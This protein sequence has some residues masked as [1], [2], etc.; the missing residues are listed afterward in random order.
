MEQ[1]KSLRGY[2]AADDFHRDSMAHQDSEY[3]SLL[4]KSS[5]LPVEDDQGTEERDPNMDDI[6]AQ[7]FA[8]LMQ[9]NEEKNAMAIRKVTV[10]EKS[11][12]LMERD[13]EKDINSGSNNAYTSVNKRS[14]I[15]T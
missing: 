2:D 11:I 4:R 8:K 13:D 5:F 1:R 10:N 6:I 9:G 14:R 12:Q 3:Y 15:M 7:N